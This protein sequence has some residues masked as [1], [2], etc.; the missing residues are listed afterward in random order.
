MDRKSQYKHKS[1]D[2][3]AIRSRNRNEEIGTS[4]IN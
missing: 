4:S 3:D 1:D 2:V